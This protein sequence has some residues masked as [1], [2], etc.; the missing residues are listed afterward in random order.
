[1]RRSRIA[2]AAIARTCGHAWE[3]HFFACAVGQIS[4]CSSRVPC[5]IKRGVSRSSRTLGAGMRW[6]RWRCRT[7]NA[8]ADGE[9]VW[10]W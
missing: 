8:T 4:G 3:A 5:P 10:S 9:V 6:T 2:R 7:S 1:M